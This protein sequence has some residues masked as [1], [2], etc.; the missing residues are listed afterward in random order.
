M[1]ILEFQN[2]VKCYENSFG[3]ILKVP[4]KDR[5][6]ARAVGVDIVSKYIN[7]IG[8]VIDNNFLYDFDGE[9]AVGFST[10]SRGLVHSWKDL[11]FG[12]YF[13]KDLNI[14]RI[15]VNG[16][17]VQLEKEIVD[18]PAFLR[19][20]I[21]PSLK[22]VF[23]QG[24]D[25]L[26]TSDVE[27]KYPLLIYFLN[28]NAYISS[29]SVFIENYIEDKTKVVNIIPDIDKPVD[30]GEKITFTFNRNLKEDIYLTSNILA[31]TT[32]DKESFTKYTITQKNNTLSIVPDFDFA[33]NTVY[34]VHLTDRILDYLNLPIF[35]EEIRF[36]TEEAESPE[37]SVSEL[38]KNPNGVYFMLKNFHK[39]L[40]IHEVLKDTTF[41][42]YYTPSFYN[43]QTKNYE[44]VEVYDVDRKENRPANPVIHYNTKFFEEKFRNQFLYN[45]HEYIS[46]LEGVDLTREELVTLK[47]ILYRNPLDLNFY[48]GVQS[49]LQFLIQIYAFAY[50]K[51]F[52]FVEEDPYDKF[53]YRIT[54]D[55]DKNK[56]FSNIKKTVHPLG[57]TERYFEITDLPSNRQFVHDLSNNIKFLERELYNSFFAIKSNIDYCLHSTS[58]SGGEFTI[59]IVDLRRRILDFKTAH[60]AGQLTNAEYAENVAPLQ[61]ELDSIERLSTDIVRTDAYSE[62]DFGYRWKRE[63]I[64]LA[65]KRQIEDRQNSFDKGEISKF[66]RDR[67]ISILLDTEF[68]RRENERNQRWTES[69]IGED[70]DHVKYG[71]HYYLNAVDYMIHK[72]SIDE[73][74]FYSKTEVNYNPSSYQ[75]TRDYDSFDLLK[76]LFD[77]NNY[78]HE[79]YH[80]TS[81]R[82]VYLLEYLL[83]GVGTEFTWEVYRYGRL[84]L[85]TEKQEDFSSDLYPIPKYE[86][87]DSFNRNL[88]F[89]FEPHARKARMTNTHDVPYRVVITLYNSNQNDSWVK[90]VFE[91]ELFKFYDKNVKRTTR[92]WYS[93][94][95]IYSLLKS[96]Q[97]N[98]GY[99]R[100][101][102]HIADKDHDDKLAV[103][104]ISRVLM[105][106]VGYETT[107][108]YDS[109]NLLRE[110]C[111]HTNFLQTENIESGKVRYK[112]NYLKT[113]VGT[114][115]IWSFYKQGRFQKVRTTEYPEIEEVRDNEDVPERVSLELKRDNWKKRIS[116]YITMPFMFK[117][118][119]R[120][121]YKDYHYINTTNCNSRYCLDGFMLNDFKDNKVAKSD[122][123]SYYGASRIYDDP[124][125]SEELNEEKNFGIDVRI[126][127]SEESGAIDKR[128]E[129]VVKY[130]KKGIGL[131]YL[132]EVFNVNKKLTDFTT[133][134]PELSLLTNVGDHYRFK[135]TLLNNGWSQQ[136]NHTYII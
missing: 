46:A 105:M 95:Q 117:H 56:W 25:I 5:W 64:N 104:E 128:Q 18:E 61:N 101:I 119:N 32:G 103:S 21:D 135:L 87:Q 132:W 99:V 48:K 28:K 126:V 54:T 109:Y 83:S 14:I 116:D 68:R 125:L 36:I 70:H 130:N 121:L 97:L 92:E 2:F 110:L 20:N 4:G 107:C 118:N 85:R 8:I 51:H 24:N 66:I 45:F 96:N 53:V 94:A 127:E 31:I 37:I 59:K 62:R 27:I 84:I 136:M 29:V 47:R 1:K 23:R 108:C 111:E 98:N 43:V 102:K 12:Y 131:E 40:D 6:D 50:G 39:I 33:T 78:S 82:S 26:Y 13:R 35:S 122:R 91:Y 90:R 88:D 41:N 9:F 106:P 123:D 52:V 86:H 115:Y 65:I 55:L 71:F 30:V 100:S 67:D 58:F 44:P 112:F 10:K 74:S 76:E 38:N 15:V 75:L 3:H 89:V 79:N 22:V 19:I 42:F 129:V 113:G 16:E 73:K 57:W 34:N 80:F 69:F 63:P 134:Q 60:E 7:D 17:L 49:Q 93:H 72:G 133:L 81:G 120:H 11:Y 124:K 77:Y 114:E